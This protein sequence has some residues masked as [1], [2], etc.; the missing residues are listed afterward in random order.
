MALRFISGASAKMIHMDS[1]I[2]NYEVTRHRACFALLRGS[3]NIQEKDDIQNR[4]E[5][6]ETSLPWL[7]VKDDTNTVAVILSAGS[8]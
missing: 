8:L 6:A 5:N 2:S 7:W 4:C 1:A 3:E